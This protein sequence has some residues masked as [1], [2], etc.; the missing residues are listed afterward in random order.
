M[1]EPTVSEPTASESGTALTLTP[2]LLSGSVQDLA[3]GTRPVL[4]LGPSLGTSVAVLWE[5]A[6]PHLQEAFT[7]IGWDLPGHGDAQPHPEPFE[8]TDLADAVEHLVAELARSHGMPADL[9]V[10]AA[11]V[12]IAGTVS[13]TLALRPQTRFTRLAALCTAAKIG[14]PQM[15]SERAELVA[16]AGT[17]TMVEGSAQ[18]WFAPGFMARHPAVVTGLLSSLQHADRHSYAQACR[19]LGRY[20]LTAE[21]SGVA[22][23]LLV[24][25]GEQDPVC[26]PSAVRDLAAAPHTRTAVLDGVAHQAPAEAPE[27]TA[28]LLKE[29]LDD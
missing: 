8:I 6:V 19:A 2:Q 28:R 26:P 4:V 11:G 21:L 22:R 10:Y 16:Q 15:W 13:L 18:R 25:S 14:D 29:F 24:I 12:S 1:P 27:A 3:A 20:D 17:P 5:G 23:P 9:P 7:V